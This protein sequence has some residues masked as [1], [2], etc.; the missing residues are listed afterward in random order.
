MRTKERNAALAVVTICDRIGQPGARNC[1]HK[2]N[3]GKRLQTKRHPPW[4]RP[5]GDPERGLYVELREA[6]E[7]PWEEGRAQ[8]VIVRKGSGMVV[9]DLDEAQPL[10]DVLSQAAADLEADTN[11]R[12]GD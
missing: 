5:V 1:H 8:L 10:I 12:E 7:Q 2:Q 4:L 11:G 9:V 6:P 3:E